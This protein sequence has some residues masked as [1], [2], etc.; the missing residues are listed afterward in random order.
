[1]TVTYAH[2]DSFVR[3]VKGEIWSRLLYRGEI[4]RRTDS[5]IMSATESAAIP[6]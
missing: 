5:T 3:V 4:K 2:S 6:S 1:M